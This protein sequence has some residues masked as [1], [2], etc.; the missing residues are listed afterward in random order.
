MADLT[1]IERQKLEKLFCMGRGYVLGFVDRTYSEF[2]RDYG[3]EID[4]EEYQT[5]GFSKANRMR[6]F[7]TKKPNNIVGRVINDMI[8]LAIEYREEQK[9]FSEINPLLISN[10]QDIA[11]R[12]L[13]PSSLVIELDALD[14]SDSWEDCK[15]LLQQMRDSIDKDK[16][17]T[18]IDR[19]HTSFY[20][21]IKEKCKRH[22]IKVINNSKENKPLHS[23][24]GEYVKALEQG[25]HLDSEM[26]KRILKVNNSLM[27]P[28]NEVRN[29]K[30]FAHANPLLNHEESL[31]IFNYIVITAKF[32]NS[33]EKKIWDLNN[34][35]LNQ[36]S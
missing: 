16:P 26:S 10:C 9:L 24:Y 36:N 18:I 7:W 2:F 29:K 20:N 6:T 1:S 17:E 21:F 4:T 25:N 5:N 3:I 32:I 13:S 12:L 19:L 8:P 31:L 27:E 33:L 34:P 11:T 23:L 30:S 22:G 35:D 28:F 14:T 15:K